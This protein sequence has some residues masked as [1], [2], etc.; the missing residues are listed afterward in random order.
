LPKPVIAAVNGVAAGAGA[1]IAL[2]CDIV[3]ASSQAAFIQ[4]FSK[5]GLVPD[6]GGS[7]FLP[8]LVGYQ[9]A[10]GLML[11]GDRVSAEEAERMGM[12]YRVLPAESFHAD[13]LALAHQ[14]SNMPTHA[15]ALTK[16]MMQQSMQ[17]NLHEQLRLEEAMQIE[18]GQTA[19][20]HEG[21]QAFMQKRKPVFSG[22]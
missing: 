15:L 2:A 3:L 18:A 9:K 4:A 21:V 7:Y 17:S 16:Q 12:I 14:L 1:N 10:L 20:Y 8:R 13:S 22:K 11:T 5:I 6:S 19:D